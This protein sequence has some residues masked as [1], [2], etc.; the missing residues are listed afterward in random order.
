MKKKIYVR[1][2]F[3]AILSII[4]S[5]LLLTAVYYDLYRKQI[6]EDLRVYSNLVKEYSTMDEIA[7]VGT[8]V[9]EDG[10]RITL[11]DKQGSVL[12][13]NT[14][15]AKEMGNHGD[16]PEIL[17]TI[18]EGEGQAVRESITLSKSTFYYASLLPHI[19]PKTITY[20]IDLITPPVLGFPL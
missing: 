17:Q 3:I 1:I 9:K 7:S 15:D 5:M 14:T 16:R 12:Y 19:D 20:T 18:T 10:V 11:L 4:L 2:V 13:D 6:M 8:E